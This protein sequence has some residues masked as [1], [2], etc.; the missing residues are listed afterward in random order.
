MSLTSQQ[1]FERHLRKFRKYIYRN[2]PF[3]QQ[4]KQRP[5]ISYCLLESSC[6][7]L[8]LGCPFLSVRPGNAAVSPKVSFSNRSGRR[9]RRKTSYLASSSFSHSLNSFLNRNMIS[10]SLVSVPSSSFC[11]ISSSSFLNSSSLTKSLDLFF[12][13]FSD[14]KHTHNMS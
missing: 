12:D 8:S 2:I 9:R 1:L 13:F 4:A 3:S 14:C 11:F 6:G 7:N 5:H 10:S